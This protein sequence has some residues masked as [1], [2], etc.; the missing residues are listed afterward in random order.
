[1][2]GLTCTYS[3]IG[4]EFL[5]L[6]S[7]VSR[8]GIKN[9]VC[10]SC[11]RRFARKYDMEKHRKLHTK[12]SERSPSKRPRLSS[13]STDSRESESLCC[14]ASH[15]TGTRCERRA[16]VVHQGHYDFLLTCG[17]LQ[18]K[19]G[20]DHASSTSSEDADNSTDSKMDTYTSPLAAATITRAC[21]V[22]SCRSPG[23]CTH[24]KKAVKVH[25]EDHVDFALEGHLWHPTGGVFE[26]HGTFELLDINQ[27][28]LTFYESLEQMEKPG[29]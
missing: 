24:L 13:G 3:F 7:A 9:F 2:S 22:A 25:H 18:C 12:Q 10:D 20:E 17:T 8:R 4:A 26:S 11:G 16:V 1:M 21:P 19:H 6:T 27:D 5:V 14:E 23:T 29:F 15:A 28:F